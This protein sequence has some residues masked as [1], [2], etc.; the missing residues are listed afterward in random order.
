MKGV[1][2]DSRQVNTLIMSFLCAITLKKAAQAHDIYHEFYSN[3]ER[4]FDGL[5]VKD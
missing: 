4:F 5:G 2:V 3:F 1:L